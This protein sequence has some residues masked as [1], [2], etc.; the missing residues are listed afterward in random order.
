M[1]RAGVYSRLLSLVA[2]VLST[3]T[4]NGSF[5]VVHIKSPD[6]R[7]LERVIACIEL[8]FGL[9]RLLGENATDEDATKR[10]LVFEDGGWITV[11]HDDIPLDDIELNLEDFRGALGGLTSSMLR[12]EAVENAVYPGKT[13]VITRY[14]SGRRKGRLQVPEGATGE[15]KGPRYAPS[16]FLADLARSRDAK[17]E[18]KAG[19]LAEEGRPEATV[20]RAAALVGRPHPASGLRDVWSSP[21]R[22]AVKLRF[23]PNPLAM[24]AME[25]AVKGT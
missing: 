13:A 17:A 7:P 8:H 22:N 11:V 19:L 4:M 18:L 14:R 12:T 21:P 3:A 5:E 1:P 20:A 23:E 9:L 6:E 2:T 16:A 25:M 24:A 15:E 10:V